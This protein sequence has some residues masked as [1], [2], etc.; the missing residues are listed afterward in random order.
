VEDL[1]GSELTSLYN[2]RKSE[3]DS[4]Y[5]IIS[6]DVL[7]DIIVRKNALPTVIGFL[8]SDYS[9]T[10]LHISENELI[11]T[12]YFPIQFLTDL[13]AK[14]EVV[15]YV[16]PVFPAFTLGT[17][18][19]S[20]GDATQ[21]SDVARNKYNL[22]GAGVKV[23]VLSDS[24]NKLANGTQEALDIATSEL[25]PNVQDEYNGISWDNPFGG[26]DEG[27][28][29]LQIVHDVAPGADLAFRNGFLSESDFAKGIRDLFDYAACDII[30]D[31]IL[32]ITEPFYTDGLVSQ[33]I[34]FVTSQGVTYFTS[35]GNFGQN[36]YEALYNPVLSGP[37]KDRHIFGS[38]ND[39]QQRIML[40]KGTY[41]IV[42]Q[43]YDD[44][45]S[46]EPNTFGNPEGA[47]YDFDIYLA[48]I[49][50]NILFGFNRDNL[51]GDPIEVLPFNVNVEATEAN[52][53]I[54]K[55]A[56]PSTPVM[57]KYIAFR[58]GKGFGQ[59]YNVGTSTI[60][61]HTTNSNAITVAAARW[62]DLSKVE[63]FS[64]RGAQ[65]PGEIG[66][67][68]PDITAPNGGITAVTSFERPDGTYRFY[69]TS[70]S[71]PH[72][73]ATAALLL[74]AKNSLNANVPDVLSAMTVGTESIGSGLSY[75]SGA[76]FIQ[77]DAMLE[78][79]IAPQAQI[80][81]LSYTP[82]IGESPDGLPGQIIITAIVDGKFV[83]PDAQLYLDGVPLAT[84]FTD[85]GDGTYT[86]TATVNPFLGD[87]LIQVWN[88]G[89]NGSLGR[90]SEGVSFFEDTNTIIISANIDKNGSDA[91]KKYGEKN[92][93]FQIV[94]LDGSM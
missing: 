92:P 9:V 23:G 79:L 31:D 25:P 94:L 50:G 5:Q 4:I 37:E 63:N 18:L 88:P 34:D 72:A 56:G 82:F 87:P 75:E 20:E 41:E 59:E 3:S 78:G 11:I 60:V 27:R 69:G 29:M 33:A 77:A 91:F 67:N 70:A 66:Y 71:A 90:F 76:G 84:T 16:R 51:G 6:D 24:Y 42:L 26:Q 44:F 22:S 7:I 58:S 74:E 8:A 52:L 30:V 38:S 39:T 32:Y 65:N 36:A 46:D 89:I 64:S 13:N 47:K 45:Y 40:Q 85:N 2:N 12:T 35:A 62:S 10:P 43:W 17:G 83:S 14:D 21:N 68:K 81:N 80:S 19:V 1:I 93:D 54:K 53:I 15:N 86:L 48:D 28:A 49:N 55:I 57:L 73:A 61:G